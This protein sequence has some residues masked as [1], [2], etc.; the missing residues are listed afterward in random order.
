M[1]NGMVLNQVSWLLSCTGTFLRIG[2][3]LGDRNIGSVPYKRIGSTQL[4]P[5]QDDVGEWKVRL[6]LISIPYRVMTLTPCTSQVVLG[7][8]RNFTCHGIYF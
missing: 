3:Q 5:A 6:P 2:D 4:L 1:L 7:Y 8:M